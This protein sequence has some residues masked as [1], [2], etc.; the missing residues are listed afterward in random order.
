[1]VS[2]SVKTGAQKILTLG[3]LKMQKKSAYT[4]VLVKDNFKKIFRITGNFEFLESQV[5]I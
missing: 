2:L 5:D 4:H 1:M 3:Y